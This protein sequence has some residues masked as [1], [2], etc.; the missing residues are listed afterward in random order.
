MQVRPEKVSLRSRSTREKCRITCRWWVGAGVSYRLRPMSQNY[1]TLILNSMAK[2]SLGVPSYATYPTR[3]GLRWI[4]ITWNWYR[5][6]KLPHST[7]LLTEVAVLSSRYPSEVLI[8][9]F[10]TFKKPSGQFL[11]QLNPKFQ[12]FNVIF[13]HFFQLQCANQKI[14]L[15]FR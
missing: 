14:D 1:T 3:V 15:L 5:W 12:D 8:F 11:I 4:S 7:W 10:Y 13:E 6:I 9:W 2:P